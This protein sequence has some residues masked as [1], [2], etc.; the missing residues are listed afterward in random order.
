MKDAGFKIGEPEFTPLL[1]Y[2]VSIGGPP[3]R[4]DAVNCIAYALGNKLP[5]MGVTRVLPT[6][7]SILITVGEK[8]LGQLPE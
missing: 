3:E 2:E 4:S 8:E 5:I 6:G 1:L 7:A